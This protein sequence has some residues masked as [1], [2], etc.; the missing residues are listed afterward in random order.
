[1]VVTM[2]SAVRI[3]ELTDFPDEIILKVFACLKL[4]DLFKCGLVAK[5]FR[6]ISH[7]EFL[8]QRIEVCGQS[9][10][11]AFIQVIMDRGCKYLSLNLTYNSRKLDSV[12]IQTIVNNCVQLTELNLK[13]INISVKDSLFLVQN[14]TPNLKKLNLG[15]LCYPDPDAHVKILVEK[16]NQ[17]QELRLHYC[18]PITDSAITSIIK[19]L[20]NT[21]ETLDLYTCGKVSFSKLMELSVMTKLKYLNIWSKKD[22]ERLR[23]ELRNLKINEDYTLKEQ[24]KNRRNCLAICF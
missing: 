13:S 21:L 10:S 3:L 22:I 8:W 11:A 12:S 4:S 9:V 1:M 6:T 2:K 24:V 19:E 23:I 15:W 18:F 20:K 16:C 14:L 17:L 7:D 5:R